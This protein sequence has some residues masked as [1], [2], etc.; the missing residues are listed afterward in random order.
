[1]HLRTTE[2]SGERFEILP[3]GICCQFESNTFC[4][5]K[6]K[7]GKD[8]KTTVA[9]GRHR[10]WLSDPFARNTVCWRFLHNHDTSSVKYYAE[11]LKIKIKIAFTPWKLIMCQALSQTLSRIINSLIVTKALGG[12]S[13]DDCTRKPRREGGRCLLYTSDAADECVNV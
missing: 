11:S 8:I 12:W 10:V 7:V 13:Y 4:K 5:K 9:S 1:M 2:S 3:P 6:N